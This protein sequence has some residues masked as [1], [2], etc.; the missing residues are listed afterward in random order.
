LFG[1]INGMI[2]SPSV[3]IAEQGHADSAHFVV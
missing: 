2:V 1:R 3:S